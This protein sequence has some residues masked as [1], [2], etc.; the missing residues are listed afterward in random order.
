MRK[1]YPRVQTIGV[2]FEEDNGFRGIYPK[3]EGKRNISDFIADLN[4][5][6]LDAPKKMKLTDLLAKH[7]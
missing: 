6:Y 2:I 5:E 3:P 4:L 7:K 1:F